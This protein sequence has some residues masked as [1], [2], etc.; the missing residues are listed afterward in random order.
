MAMIYNEIK[1]KKMRSF[2]DNVTRADAAA[3]AL[4]HE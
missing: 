4:E 3:Y 2:A 1:K